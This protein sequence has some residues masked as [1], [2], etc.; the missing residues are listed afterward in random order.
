VSVDVSVHRG[1]TPVRDLSAAD[2]RVT[3]NGVVQ[4]V[5]LIEAAAM[6]VDVTLIVDVSDHTAG[7]ISDR[8]S[9]RDHHDQ[10]QKVLAEMTAILRPTDR[11]RLVAS[12][13]YVTEVVPLSPVSR[14]LV[15]RSFRPPAPL[16]LASTYDALTAALM[17]TD[18]PGRR[19]LVVAWIKPVDTVSIA[20]AAVVRALAQRSDAVLH[21]VERGLASVRR[22]G[23]P[24]ILPMPG[25]L[26]A[27]MEIER[28]GGDSS[29][30]GR[31]GDRLL[32][33]PLPTPLTA[34]DLTPRDVVGGR[35]LAR[36]W[37]HHARVEPAVLPELAALTGGT[38]RGVGALRDFDAAAVF[39]DIFEE[40][41][42]GYVIRYRAEGVRR[43]GAHQIVVTVPSHPEAEIRA[44]RGYTIESR[45]SP[46]D[47]AA[48]RPSE[49]SRLT[50]PTSLDDIVALFDTGDDARFMT[51]LRQSRSLRAFIE[52]YRE[53]DA[54]WPGAPRVESIFTLLLGAAGLQSSDE[55]VRGAA[56]SL[57]AW[58]ADLVRQPLGADAFECAWYRTAV[59]AAS[60]AFLADTVRTAADRALERCPGDARLHL[61]RAVAVDQLWSLDT[62]RVRSPGE[63]EKD[64]DAGA[65]LRQYEGLAREF[66]E[67]AQEARIRGAW[68][69]YRSTDV[70]RAL[71][72]LSGS[73]RVSG[74]VI[75]DYFGHLVRAQALRRLDRTDEAVDAYRAALMSWP[76]AQ[77][78]R[79]GLMTLLVTRGARAEASRLSEEVQG[80]PDSQVDPWWVYWLGDYRS[81]SQQVRHLRELAR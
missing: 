69:A 3:D 20:D 23:A 56:Q 50:A 51:V 9:A 49:P 27:A 25:R 14:L 79:I 35:F 63:A 47:T 31:P 48:A 64:L 16:G 78:A 40:F 70:A 67:V 6:P 22:G 38:H 65:V 5:E 66:P 45:S 76:G 80:A 7:A 72:V 36:T 11:L 37:R 1:G 4:R 57:L 61:A 53:A 74:D 21:I 44:R 2:F 73:P 18:E 81:F 32:S 34:A 52:S 26:Q 39:K 8:M 42:R 12:D 17:S 59:A 75:V 54:Q 62:A 13:T 58:H 24:I 55:A 28:T 46:A 60:A 10:L 30:G 77:S 15:D 68:V 19:H 71:D 29:A 33:A 43:D 41:R